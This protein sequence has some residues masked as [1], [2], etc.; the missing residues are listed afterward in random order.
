M[1]IDAL[2]VRRGR[3]VLFRLAEEDHPAARQAN[4]G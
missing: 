1:R 3:Y 2:I 4:F